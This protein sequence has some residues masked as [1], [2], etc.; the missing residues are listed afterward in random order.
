MNIRKANIGDL[1]RILEL[2]DLARGVMRSDG[3]LSQWPEG[4]PRTEKFRKDITE[5]NC[6]VMEEVG[7][8][9]GTVPAEQERGEVV[10]TWAFIP[11]PDPTYSII[12]DGQWLNDTLPYYVVHRIASTPESHGV[13]EAVL[14][15]C[16]SQTNNIRIDT[17]R[18]N[19]IMR[20]LL[21]KHGFTE[22]GLIHIE[23]GDERVAYQKIIGQR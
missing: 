16:F 23:N 21:R 19:H 18:D 2:R 20:H 1:K 22:C 14:R 7:E 13:M 3:N 11:G 9:E 12:Y 4:Y 10:A 8:P 17:H 5:G 15:F 6:Y